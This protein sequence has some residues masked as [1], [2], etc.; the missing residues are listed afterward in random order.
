MSVLGRNVRAIGVLALLLLAAVP[1]G[2]PSATA[3][4]TTSPGSEPRALTNGSAV[5]NFSAVVDRIVVLL[6]V[7]GG[8]LLAIVW[9]RVALSWFSNDVTKKVQAKDRARD[10]LVGTLLFAGALS[11][12][13]WGLARWVLTGS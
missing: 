3:S 8:G 12:L 4:P 11:G 7:S 10:A 5:A 13:I 2:L 6:G 1:M 9:A